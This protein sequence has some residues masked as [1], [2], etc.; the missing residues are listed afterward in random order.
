MNQRQTTIVGLVYVVFMLLLVAVSPRL[1][2]EGDRRL[3][4]LL[5]TGLVAGLAC[6]GALWYLRNRPQG[7]TASDSPEL[8]EL[9]LLVRSADARLRQSLPGTRRVADLP[10]IYILGEENSAK[11]QTVLQAELD[12]EL[13]AGAVFRDGAVE[14][15]ALV[16][17]W[18]TRAAAVVEAGGK[19]FVRK[20]LWAKLTQLTQARN[21]RAALRRNDRLPTRAVVVC[22]SLEHL[23]SAAPGSEALRSRAQTI[24]DRL[25]Q[26]SETVGISLP[27]YVLFTKLDTMPAFP[28]FAAN[29]TDAEIRQPVGS[30]LPRSDAGAGLYGERAA[31]EISERFEE[32]CHSLG[33]YRLELLTRGGASADLA[34]AY[35]FPRELRKLQTGIVELLVGAGRPSQLGVNP[36]LRGFFFTGVRA[37]LSEEAPDSSGQV[38][39]SSVSVD[40]PGAVFSRGISARRRPQWVFL[41]HLFSQVIL[42][43]RSALE[44]SQASTKVKVLKRSLA[45]TAALALLVYLTGLLVSF[46]RNASLES[47]LAAAAALPMS[48]VHSEA[49]TVSDLRNLEQLR[50][51]FLET[52][53][54]RAD[55]APLSYRWGL[56]KGDRL[57]HAAC[58]AYGE[59]FR[60]VLLAPTEANLVAHFEGLPAAPQPTDDYSATYAP[61]RAYLITTAYP[62]RSTPE[63]L[64]PALLAAWTAGHAIAPETAQLVSLQFATY[65]DHLNGADPCMAALGGAAQAPPVRQARAY[66]NHF[67]GLQQVY[68]S[69][70]AGADRRFP[71]VRFNEQFPGSARF[72]VDPYTVEGAFTHGGWEFMENAM[73]HPELYTS[74]EAWVLGPV[75]TGPIDLARLHT[76]LPALYQSEFLNAWRTYLKNAHVVPSGGFPDAKEKLHQIDSPAS[77]LLELFQLIS[78]NTAVPDPAFSVPFQAPQTV[79][80]PSRPLPANSG[81]MQG[82]Q[83]LE[84]A[85]NSM[86]LVPNS[87]N[88]PAA[89]SPVIAAAS[90]AESAVETLRSGF[91]P[92]DPV[93]GMDLTS[94]HLLL[95]PIR[96]VEDLARQA[97]ARAAGG[98][99]QALCAAVQPLLNKFPF[100]PEG[101]TDATMAEIAQVFQPEKGEL[102]QYAGRLSDTVV[103]QGNTWMQAP[104]SMVKVNPAFLRFLNAAQG[105]SALFFPPGGGQPQ[106]NFTLTQEATPNLPPAT[107][108]I[109]SAVLN[110]PG[111]TKAFSWNFAPSSSIHL[112]GAGNSMTEPPGPWS[113]FHLT[114]NL[115]RH[116]APNRLE[117]IFE[118]NGHTVT[119]PTGVPLDYKY[120][121]GGTG[122]PLINPAYMRGALRCTT[123]VG[124]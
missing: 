99:G 112:A 11:T 32:L 93:G 46:S 121:V 42:A 18:Y 84:G 115:A 13:L 114:Y 26:L 124:Q 123:R 100:N 81:Y 47:R 31:A 107:L 105:I 83:G 73:A 1:G 45:A 29:L 82:L 50:A 56:F 74:G 80:P 53:S 94:E 86:L 34:R 21:F 95:A 14:P 43:D 65:A 49:P 30:L 41:P 79:V 98:G 15:T 67:Q 85:I 96:S 113:L 76:E 69:M 106:L 63:F 64:P 25:R 37:R 7:A 22:V 104:G 101:R 103:L 28:E 27:V 111:Q 117:F 60:S 10:L 108:T 70:K 4:F 116:P 120:D 122:A 75:G 44:L 78:V 66:L 91:S 52:A 89:V 38:R 12:P 6:W 57:F 102:F 16:N 9:E 8:K 54:L 3:A 119:S 58:S 109:N 59:R 88:N 5:I 23:L 35:E 55:G 24:N 20:D 36:F 110:A 19:V 61:L 51:V 2:L 118:V 48:P 40:L 68:L 71:A 92:P 87:G 77:S 72:V 33:E 62:A 97:P 90:Q 39:A 17:L